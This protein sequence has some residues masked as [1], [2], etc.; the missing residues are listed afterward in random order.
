MKGK[1]KERNEHRDCPP[2]R[3]ASAD[4]PREK[5]EGILAM[6]AWTIY[7]N[8]ILSRLAALVL[9]CITM[10]GAGA[11][12]AQTIVINE[13]MSNVRGTDSGVGSPGDRNEFIEIFNSADDT[14]DLSSYRISD[15]DATDVI[16]PWT[17]SLILD[18]D[19]IFGTTLLAP[20][21]YAVILDPE[22][23]DSGDGTQYQPYDFPAQTL[24]VTVGNTTLGDGLSATD[25]V[26]LIDASDDTVSSYGTPGDMND[27]IPFD[28]GDGVSA[29][30][31]SPFVIDHEMNWIGC[32]D[33]A[34][35]TPGGPNSTY[36]SSEVTIPLSGFYLT[37]QAVE[38][39][40]QVTISAL[41]QNQ[42]EDTA[43]G[44]SVDFFFDEGWDSACTESE[45]IQTI[46]IAE[47]IPPFGCSTRIET[48]WTPEEPGNMRVSVKLSAHE[49]ARCFR[50]LK[51]GD[52]IGEIVIN[53]I[54]YHPE[55]G[56]EWIELFNRAAF[57]IDI[58]NWRLVVGDDEM[59]IPANTILGSGCF[60]LMIEDRSQFYAKWGNVSAALLEPIHWSALSNGG[61]VLTV[62]D[63]NMFSFEKVSYTDITD[64]G[65]SLE[66]I[67]PDIG[68]GEPW[69]WGSSCDY[70]GAT[71]GEKNSI[72]A[73][74]SRA[75][76]LLS[77]SPNPFSPDGDGHEERTLIQYELPF[78]R[79]KVN[80]H[81]FTRTGVRMCRFLDQK[82]TG[83]TGQFVWDGRDEYGKEMP[84][85]LYIIYLEAVDSASSERVVQKAAVVIA[86]G[87]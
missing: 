3:N 81:L 1:E 30:R 66:R 8:K 2:T 71:P 55:A 18:V 38:P 57:A 80:L 4:K 13:V 85:G 45:I 24:V 46:F 44:V 7:K 70:R 15:L 75:K 60:A 78:L 5:Q 6:T 25:P 86:G 27:N 51:V 64:A 87:R 48:E 28:P 26:V 53:E 76:T 29:E 73:E 37:P 47:P 68:S 79:A 54:M 42:T 23:T 33:S 61:D 56:G 83:K 17:D 74:P 58:S 43:A 52:P 34:G 11:I 69:N 20:H 72:F 59:S 84:V 65:E 22:Y 63:K 50:M 77:V 31:V 10:L 39:H 19:V 9:V 32:A 35:C 82:D 36:S 12:N 49:K 40:E 41:V 16:V 62:E 67:N 21:R 14:V